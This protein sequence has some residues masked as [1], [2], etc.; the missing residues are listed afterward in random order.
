MSEKF[1]TTGKWLD[2]AYAAGNIS[3]GTYGNICRENA[4]RLLER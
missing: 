3:A 4:L 2:E 1:V